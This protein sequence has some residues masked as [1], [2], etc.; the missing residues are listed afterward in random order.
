MEVIS[1]IMSA[2]KAVGVSGVLLLGICRHES[3]DFTQNYAPMDVGSP[4]YG[5]CQIKANTAFQLGFS[6]MPFVLNDSKV[7]ALYS[8]KY[9]KYQQERYG[10]NWVK[11]TA[12]YNAGSY[13]PSNKVPGCPRNLK[14]VKLVK[15]KLPSDLQV[16]LEC[17]TN[18]EF[19]EVE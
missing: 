7:N 19:A 4:S 14:Y 6:G 12:S 11:L 8:A 1:L 15:A 16:K 10:D 3:A 2:A 9:L 17:G 13:L 5:V 18:Q